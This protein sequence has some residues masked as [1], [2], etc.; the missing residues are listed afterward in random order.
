LQPTVLPAS[1]LLATL[2]DHVFD[3]SVKEQKDGTFIKEMVSVDEKSTRKLASLL[4]GLR[5]KGGINR[6]LLAD[7]GRSEKKHLR[8]ARM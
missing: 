8:Q 4:I 7:A 5:K 6:T 2:K 3:A 1:H